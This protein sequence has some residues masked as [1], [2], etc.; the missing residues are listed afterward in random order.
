MLAKISVGAKIAL[1]IA[2]MATA[3]IGVAVVAYSSLESVSRASERL[4]ATT[5]EIKLVAGLSQ[6]AL[7]I[8]RSE[9]RILAEP[10]KIDASRAE[11]AERRRSF[12]S[13]MA[14]L[15]SDIDDGER[16]AL[17]G[18]IDRL[19]RT[20]FTDLDAVL[21]EGEQQRGR[22][23]DEAQARL[24]ELVAASRADVEA[25]T[26][27][28]DQLT[29]ASETLATEVAADARAVAHASELFLI[30]IALIGIVVGIGLGISVSRWGVTA[31]LSR[32]VSVIRSLAGGEL[33]VEVSGA[34]R[35]DE[36]GTLAS[37]A[38]ELRESL[39]RG[40]EAER[41]AAEQK[42]LA[43]RAS[44][45]AMLRL[46]DEFE[47]AVS[48]VVTEVGSAAEQL[49][50]NATA[51]ASVT[52][53]TESQVLT[54][55]AAAEQASANVGAVAAA[56]EELSAAIADVVRSITSAATGANTANEEAGR[57]S[58]SVGA[59]RDVVGRVAT[60]TSLIR[61]VAEKTN[62][63]ALNAT[64]EAAR[65]G[66][67]GRG[68]A[69]VAAEVKQLAEQTT[70]TTERIDAEMAD[71]QSATGVTIE[72]VE[73]IGRMIGE[74]REGAAQVASAAEEQGA[75]T[76]EIAR[77]VNEAAKGTS[78]VSEAMSAMTQAA[79]ETGKM[80]GE[81]RIAA[82]SLSGSAGNLKSRVADFL[83]RVR[84]A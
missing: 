72:A 82:E 56:S 8:S 19:S 74:I 21:A 53:E 9:Y 60:M 27:M 36:I 45:E 38:L 41:E 47:S 49:R 23:I 35:R 25:L 12:E 39:R 84:A 75:T 24:A 4:E 63:L 64:I 1:V 34:S 43:E 11:I 31:P 2:A 55:S 61:E 73:R 76:N 7:D 66:E 44:R 69:V 5:H 57:T 22:A 32:I 16:R 13:R 83:Q 59:L 80:S 42:A 78:A 65:A 17:L 33:D 62:L 26:A 6:D 70:K 52:E 77:N 40:V 71:M 30:T 48:G 29:A 50:T 51:L 3:T 58:V 18:E 81:V 14:A 54:V 68:F 46:A 79:S 37:A 10:S 20:V 28:L 15:R 67:A